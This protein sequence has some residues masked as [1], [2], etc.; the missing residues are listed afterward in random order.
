MEEA[1][2]LCGVFWCCIPFETSR[3]GGRAVVI[4]LP[5]MAPLRRETV[6]GQ[7]SQRWK[8]AYTYVL[9]TV[10]YSMDF[11]LAA[12][13][14]EPETAFAECPEPWKYTLAMTVNAGRDPMGNQVIMATVH[15]SGSFSGGLPRTI[16]MTA[17]H[18]Y[19]IS[20]KQTD[21]LTL[22][23]PYETACIDYHRLND[24]KT[25]TGFSKTQDKEC[26][27]TCIQQVWEKLCGCV[28]AN[29]MLRHTIDAPVCSTVE[30]CE[31]TLLPLCTRR[32]ANR[33]QAG[34]RGGQKYIQLVSQCGNIY[35]V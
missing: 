3:G 35:V 7:R 18:R 1:Y 21:V 16:M 30:R 25:R 27:D 20:A 6:A 23:P 2:G 8:V 11:D 29:Y 14:R 12:E 26:E 9:H 15:D 22:P 10:C 19:V 34:P 33:K 5:D 13:L 17:T 24:T 32:P 4:D 31:C 28:S